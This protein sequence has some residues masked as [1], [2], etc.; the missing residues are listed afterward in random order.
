MVSNR[1]TTTIAFDLITA[2]ENGQGDWNQDQ[3]ADIG[4]HGR[5]GRRWKDRAVG[6]PTTSENARRFVDPKGI[7][8]SWA[9]WCDFRSIMLILIPHSAL[10]DCTLEDHAAR[11][12]RS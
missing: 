5:L 2:G 8:A 6:K 11:A 9:R 1:L 3:L 4:L 10:I 7:T 12:S